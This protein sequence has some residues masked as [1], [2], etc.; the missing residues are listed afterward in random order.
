MLVFR[1]RLS[2][3][4]NFVSSHRGNLLTVR[5]LS[6]ET[7]QVQNSRESGSVCVFFFLIRPMRSAVL[8][9]KYTNFTC[10]L[11]LK[12]WTW[13]E[14][15][16]FG[17]KCRKPFFFSFQDLQSMFFQVSKTYSCL[18]YVEYLPS[19]C[20]YSSTFRDLLIPLS[21]SIRVRIPISIL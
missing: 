13:E 4:R 5:L 9:Y 3:V 17:Q 16:K 14:N 18:S 20:L 1:V 15:L 2:Y 12:R 7:R 19:P 8:K 6:R 10:N 21:N 11:V